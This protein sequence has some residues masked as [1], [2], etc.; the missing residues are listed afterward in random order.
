M[1]L[2]LSRAFKR[3]HPPLS[4]TLPSLLEDSADRKLT[5]RPSFS[6]RLQF[7]LGFLLL[8]FLTMA[9]IIGS[10]MA[11]NRIQKKLTFFQSSERFLFEVEQARRWE[12]NYFLYGT[13]L[14]DAAQSA[15]NA[16]LLL[17]QN[18]K[19]YLQNL[20]RQTEQINVSS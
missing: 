5:E 10:I 15:S 3:T 17:S 6:F 16:K 12:K 13:N 19:E 1:L 4:R 2:N 20:P 11:I 18:L 14:I 8:F 9:I 7:A